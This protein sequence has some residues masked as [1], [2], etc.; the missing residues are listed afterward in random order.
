M[1]TSRVFLAGFLAAVGVEGAAADP[2]FPA[3]SDALLQV[4]LK[5]VLFAH[6][7]VPR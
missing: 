7:A 3:G 5:S 1:L 6:V 2:F 4:F